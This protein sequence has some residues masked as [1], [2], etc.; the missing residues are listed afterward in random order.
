[1]NQSSTTPLE[2]SLASSQDTAFLGYPASQDLIST[3]DSDNDQDLSFNKAKFT[4][5]PRTSSERPQLDTGATLL[6]G[7]D[8]GTSRT[9]IQLASAKNDASTLN[10]EIPTVVGYARSGILPGILPEN[11]TVF[12]GMKPWPINST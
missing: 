3:A 11:R 5:G 1:M 10:T 6:V 12:F 2:D 8:L 4:S 9:C 7:L